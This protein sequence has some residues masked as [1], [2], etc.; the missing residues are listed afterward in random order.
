MSKTAKDKFPLTRRGDGRYCKKVR[1][2]YVYFSGT[3]DEALA[4]WLRV[5]DDLLAGRKPTAKSETDGVTVQYVCNAYLA[6]QADKRDAGQ[7]S[8]VTWLDYERTCKRILAGVGKGRA[9]ADLGPDDFRSIRQSLA[10]TCGLNTVLPTIVK[11]RSVF[12]YA[13][14]NRLIDRPPYYGSA[15]D[16]PSAKERRVFRA[17]QEAEHGSKMFDASDVRKLIVAADVHLRAMIYLGINCG[18]GNNDVGTLPTKAID[19]ENGWVEHARSKTGIGRRCPLWPETI[20][21][22]K[23][24]QAKRPTPKTEGAEKLFFI[25]K[26]GDSW[27]KATSDNP[28]AKAFAKL[29]KA[30]GLQQQGRGYYALRHTFR[31]IARR[32]RD[33]DAVR[34]IM[35]HI[36]GHVEAGYQ[37][38]AVE[39]D[40]L[41]AV[42]N[43]VRAWLL[44]AT[45]KRRILRIRGKGKAGRH[46]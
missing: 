9:A 31:S 2:Q 41:V 36:N 29:A 44:A 42:V 46:G 25:T 1:G 15:F 10:T 5:K 38:E 3:A 20:A 8:P 32:C 40:R 4:E 45:A 16:L 34:S 39:D 24:S 35:G 13:V 12:N 33:L 23:A 11:V 28:V 30:K 27:S 17:R 6:A 21:A 7:L 43:V 19:L 18:F 37:H 14:K 26:Y 22:L